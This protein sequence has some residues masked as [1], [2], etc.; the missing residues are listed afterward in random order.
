MPLLEST[1]TGTQDSTLIQDAPFDLST[2]SPAF[3]FLLLPSELRNR[4][5]D[6]ALPESQSETKLKHKSWRTEESQE[7]SCIMGVSKQARV[8][9][10]PFV[11]SA[12]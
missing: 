9:F 2:R 12:I 8:E 3:P 11:M 10:G 4:V 5:Y 7:F 6:L 1:S